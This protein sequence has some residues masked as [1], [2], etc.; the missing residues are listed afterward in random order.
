MLSDAVAIVGQ[1]FAGGFERYRLV[2]S[3]DT[4]YFRFARQPPRIVGKDRITWL[5]PTAR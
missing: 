3:V 2:S 4:D 1:T 5:T